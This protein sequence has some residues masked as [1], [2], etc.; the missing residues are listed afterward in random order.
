VNI[1]FAIPASVATSVADQI[2]ER[3]E[4]VHP[5]LGVSLASLT[6]Q[7]AE[8]FGLPVEAG[9]LVVSVAPGSPAARAGIEP[10]DVITR[11]EGQRISDAGDLIATLRDYRP[12]ETVRLTVFSGGE[13]RQVE[14]RLGERR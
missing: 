11:L 9:A 1:G 10:R 4:A 5:Y 7:I 12:G 6:P 14:V 2:I 8:R 13:S 3:G